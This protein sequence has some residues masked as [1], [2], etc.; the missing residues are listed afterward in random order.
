MV[1]DAT[2]VK[3]EPIDCKRL[4]TAQRLIF[5]TYAVEAPDEEA[6]TTFLMFVACGMVLRSSLT[7]EDASTRLKMS[8]L[9]SARSDF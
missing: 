8:Q 1:E 5:Q 6:S 4:R 3:F 9:C 2:G 7:I